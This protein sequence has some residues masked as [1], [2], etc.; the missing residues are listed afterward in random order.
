MQCASIAGSASFVLNGYPKAQVTAL[1]DTLREA[2][3]Q[4]FNWQELYA[5]IYQDWHTRRPHFP[6]PEVMATL[7]EQK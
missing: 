2:A 5:S 6:T 3:N 7:M 4:G 1:R